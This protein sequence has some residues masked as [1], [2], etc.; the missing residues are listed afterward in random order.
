MKENL[1]ISGEKI[2]IMSKRHLGVALDYFVL[3][4]KRQA[5]NDTFKE[6]LRRYHNRLIKRNR[7]KDKDEQEG[8]LTF[9][10]ITTAAVREVYVVKGYIAR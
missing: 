1:E 3:K 5:V 7:G 9:M 8:G 4:E 2:E 6:K 10:V